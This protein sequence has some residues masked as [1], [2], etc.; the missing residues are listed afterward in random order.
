VPGKSYTYNRGDQHIPSNQ[1]QNNNNNSKFAFIAPFSSWIYI[2]QNDLGY[3]KWPANED[4]MEKLIQAFN[5]S[6]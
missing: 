6:K 5:N 2:L 1:N 3:E 4:N